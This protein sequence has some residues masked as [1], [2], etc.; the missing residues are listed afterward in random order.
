M[1][2]ICDSNR[3]DRDLLRTVALQAKSSY[4]QEGVAAVK[5]L[6]VQDDFKAI[7]VGARAEVVAAA[8][9]RAWKALR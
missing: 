5:K 6:T 3:S 7:A 8:L 4:A 1:S 9:E 2:S